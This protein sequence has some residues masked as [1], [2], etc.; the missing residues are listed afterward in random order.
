MSGY[1]QLLQRMSTFKHVVQ[2]GVEGTGS[3]GSAVTALLR[4]HGFAVVEVNRP[5]RQTRRLRGKTDALD[6]EAA[7]RAVLAG[8]ATAVPKSHDGTIESIR[9]LRISLA[10]LRKCSTALTNS[11]RNVIVGAPPDLRDQLQSMTSVAL[12]RHCSRFRIAAGAPSDPR[13]ATKS[14]LR[15]LARQVITQGQEMDRLRGE[16]TDLVRRVNPALLALPG[17][18]VDSASTLLVTAGDNPERLRNEAS[19]AALCGVSPIEASSGK[20]TRHRLNRGGDRQ[21]NNALWRIAMIRT[22]NDERTRRYVARRTAEGK[23]PR[24][25]RRCLKRHIAREIYAV[26]TDPPAVQSTDDLR[27][28][29]HATGLSMQSIADQFDVS[30]TT[31]SRTERAIKPNYEFATRYRKWLKEQP[32]PAT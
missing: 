25:I 6:A 5:N 17:V 15:L 2:I 16:L 30:L 27:P 22:T 29:R 4:S 26:V 10:G 18:G 23:S 11:L 12:L 19:F 24:E 9:L 3:Y 32:T 21:A 13:E 1:H 28:L 14:T 31:I 20:Q 8:T 7:A